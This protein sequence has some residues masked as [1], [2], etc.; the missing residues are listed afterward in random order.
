MLTL[1]KVQELTC[2]TWIVPPTNPLA[3]IKGGAFDTRN[4]GNA[5]IFFAWKGE[6]S[7]GHLYL[8]RLG[9]SQQVS[10]IQLIVV[11]QELTPAQRKELPL[12]AVLLVPSSLKALHQMAAWLAQNFSGK[13]ITLTGSSGKTTT[14]SWLGHLLSNKFRVLQNPKSFNNHIGCPI[15]ILDLVPEHEI[16]LLEMG[17]SGLGELELLSSIVP[18]DITV[19]LNVGHAHLGKFG[20]QENI[21]RAKME[22]FTHQRPY[23]ISVLPWSDP[24]KGK[25]PRDGDWVLFGQGAPQFSWNP[26]NSFVTEEGQQIEFLTP[27]GRKIAKLNQLGAHVGQLFS[28]IIAV[29]YHL[30]MTWEEISPY[31]FSLPEDKGR[32]LLRKGHKKAKILDDSYNANP[33]SIV[34]MF[35]TLEMIQS[36][37][38]IAVLGNLAE[39]EEGLEESAEIIL[40]GIPETLGHLYLG[41]ESGKILNSKIREQYPKLRLTNFE[42]ID[43]IIE[44]LQEELSPT[45]VIGIKGSR[46]AHMERLVLA[47]TESKPRCPLKICGK[48][49]HCKE[50][51]E[52]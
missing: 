8:N 2:G 22:I 46:S 30:Q 14:K 6:N 37:E 41:G 29:A 45:T 50:C 49:M 21:Y 38:T 43:E 19:L 28:A 40:K 9:S 39:L 25:F 36:E 33:E 5:E 31:L 4:L 10:Q 26:E 42:Q 24:R 34:N 12:C 15:T 18:A 7:D 11:E 13:I 51:P 23:A 32:S 16:L 48:M 20:S 35:Q 44:I 52:V 47:L 3:K 17:T 27:W 1:L